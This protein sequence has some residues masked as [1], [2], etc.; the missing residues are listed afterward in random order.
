MPYFATPRS[1]TVAKKN[2]IAS[3]TGIWI[4]AKMMTLMTPPQNSPDCRSGVVGRAVK[5][6]RR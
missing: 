5:R 6:C 2:A 3:I 4:A 1:K